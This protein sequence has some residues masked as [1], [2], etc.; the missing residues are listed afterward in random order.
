[1]KLSR[2][3][4][5]VNVFVVLVVG[6]IAFP[7]ID[8]NIWGRQ[9]KLDNSQIKNLL[10]GRL[11][12]LRLG[13]S[14]DFMQQQLFVLEMTGL[15]TE[16]VEGETA[17]SKEE[18]DS[19]FESNFDVIKQRIENIG[20][21]D[22]SMRKVISED[23][24]YS[25]EIKL[26]DNQIN[27][28]VL[29]SLISEGEFQ[30][31]EFDE[32]Y[33]KPEEQDPASFSFLDGK[34]PSELLSLSD[35]VQIKDYFNSTIQPKGGW[36]IKIDFG[37]I[38]ADKVALAAAGSDTISDVYKRL[39][40]V[41]GQ[42]PVAIQYEPVINDTVNQISQSS[43]VFTSFIAQDDPN[44]RLITKALTSSLKT[45]P[46]NTPIT[47]SSIQ[48][49]DPIYGTNSID[50][51]KVLTIVAFFAISIVSFIAFGIRGIIV[52]LSIF[53]Q[54][55]IA[56]ALA[57][58]VSASLNMSLIIG[59]IGGLVVFAFS[60]ADYLVIKK[61]DLKKEFENFR[62]NYWLVCAILLAGGVMSALILNSLLLGSILGFVISIIASLIAYE[63]TFKMLV[64]L[65]GD[66]K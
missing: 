59:M 46:I 49:L 56:I 8:T 52:A 36:N 50:V 66:K 12:H 25:I 63:M 22:Y 35:A 7:S 21:G 45:R 29:G 34:K 15:N 38:N 10:G 19:L 17:L 23:G 13:N 28:S 5:L 4:V 37:E 48:N 51:I 26:P 3:L 2:I 60:I 43:V 32:N 65:F 20:M 55:L 27:S 24:K 47:I 64:N 58:S 39:W 57:K 31:Y 18:K 54:S 11:T 61:K 42:I 9:I 33:K 41:Q 6:I 53:V 62:K 44:S 40:I 14:R 1:M 16:P 30:F